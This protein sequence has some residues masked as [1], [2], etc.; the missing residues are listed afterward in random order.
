MTMYGHCYQS[1][2]WKVPESAN[3]VQCVRT[4]CSAKAYKFDRA[5]LPQRG[6]FTL[7]I[8]LEHDDNS[9]RSPNPSMQTRAAG[10]TQ[11]VQIPAFVGCQVSQWSPTTGDATVAGREGSLV[12]CFAAS[13]RP[14]GA[15]LRYRS[16]IDLTARWSPTRGDV[17]FAALRAALQ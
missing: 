6:L 17:S 2:R 9:E 7:Q 14:L 4:L 5:L 3:N 1:T 12:T 11:R 10:S 8:S 15:T 16:L 13:G